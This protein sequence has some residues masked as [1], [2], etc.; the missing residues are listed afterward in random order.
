MLVDIDAVKV[1]NVP[2]VVTDSNL[3]DIDGNIPVVII[4]I[5]VLGGSSL[6]TV[7]SLGYTSCDVYML[8]PR[9]SEEF[10]IITDSS[11]RM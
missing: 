8:T 9:K 11:G 2:Q 7:S 4:I 6:G 5:I 3:S 10:R 1:V